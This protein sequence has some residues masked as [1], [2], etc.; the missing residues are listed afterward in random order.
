LFNAVASKLWSKTLTEIRRSLARLLSVPRS[1]LGEIAR[2]SFAKVAEYQTR[3]IVHFHA[4]VRLDGPEGPASAPPASIPVELL[5]QAVRDGVSRASVTV[6]D[7]VFGWGAQLKVDPIR[8]ADLDGP[9][10]L[11]DRAVARYVAK[12]ATKSA[13]A[14][15]VDLPRSPA[16]PASAAASPPRCSRTAPPCPTPA[17]AAAPPAA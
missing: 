4:V 13:E 12:Y 6:A 11:T 8:S 17:P 1:H 7:R 3:G 5:D 9:D 2:L 10:Q 14:A 16:A 15:G